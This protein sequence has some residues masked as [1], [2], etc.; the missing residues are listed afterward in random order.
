MLR[1][2]KTEEMLKVGKETEIACLGW[3]QEMNE[4]KL[5]EEFNVQHRNCSDL[6]REMMGKPL[7]RKYLK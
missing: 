2:E 7:C 6:K 5:Q 1:F 3:G 4:W